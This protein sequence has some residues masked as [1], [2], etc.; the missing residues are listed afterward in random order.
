MNRS[1]LRTLPFSVAVLLVLLL[2]CSSLAWAQELTTGSIIGVVRDESGAVIPGASISVTN[3]ATEAQR[4]AL[5]SETGGFSIPGLSPAPY[6]IR[7]EMSGFRAYM[8][9]GL[10]LKI[11]QV[12]RLDVRLGVG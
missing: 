2:T 1:T 6:D 9:Q 7:V 11:N 4:T 5:S 10:E 3:K 12:A 8:V